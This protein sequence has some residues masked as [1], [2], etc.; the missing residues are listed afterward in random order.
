MK[1][2]FGAKS[3]GFGPVSKLAG[4]A[5]RLP[6]HDRVFTGTGTALDFARR[7][8][9]AFDRILACRPDGDAPQGL[10]ADCDY[11]ISVMDEE[12]VFQA[13]AAGRPVMMVDSLFSFWQLSD[14]PRRI[15]ELC[16]PRTR[17]GL[18]ALR[19]RLSGLTVHERKYAAHLL[20]D[21]S[22]VQNFPGVPERMAETARLGKDRVHLSGPIVDEE[23]LQGVAADQG[24][25]SDLLINLGGFKNFLLDPG[26]HDEYLRLFS[27]WVPD[28]LADQRGF[29]SVSV[30]CGGFADGREGRV[31]VRGR[32][33]RFHCPSQRDFLRALATARHCMMTPGLTSLHEANALGRLALCMPE[34]HYG[35]I[36]N[37]ESLAGTAF[38]RLGC[39]FADLIDGYDVPADDFAGTAAVAEH[40]GRLIEDDD[41][42]ARFRKRMNE[43]VE[44]YL[45]VGDDERRAGAGELRDLLAGPPFDDVVAAALPA[46]VGAGEER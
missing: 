24:P 13:V 20:A 4:L 41:A 43:R 40:V 25:G 34:Q 2:L 5:R 22:I 45:A 33:A 3:C 44:R 1:V 11:V 27:K 23:A 7:N 16:L 12:L 29:G 17:G 15:A 30:C 39:R 14:S 10:A 8:A 46:A 9:D 26:T 42:Y 32:T 37:Y 18:P 19:R 28:L 38:H 6:R 31:S 36:F 35:H 21:A